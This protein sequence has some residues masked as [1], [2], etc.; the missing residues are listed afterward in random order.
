MVDLVH[1]KLYH[2]LKLFTFRGKKCQEKQDV[3]IHFYLET[4]R[5]LLHIKFHLNWLSTSDD[6]ISPIS[7]VLFCL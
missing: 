7:I 1:V 3:L 5:W 2:S 6:E 4:D